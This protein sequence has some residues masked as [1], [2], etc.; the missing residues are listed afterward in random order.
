[1]L[2]LLS[3]SPIAIYQYIAL[4]NTFNC[5]WFNWLCVR[6]SLGRSVAQLKTGRA[7]FVLIASFRSHFTIDVSKKTQLANYWTL[8]GC[9]TSLMHLHQCIHSRN[10]CEEDASESVLDWKS[11]AIKSIPY[12]FHW[13]EKMK[14]SINRKLPALAALVVHYIVAK[15]IWSV[16]RL[17]KM[18]IPFGRQ[19][20]HSPWKRHPIATLARTV[21]LCIDMGIAVMC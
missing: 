20:C 3:S 4:C 17:V 2:L 12:F 10:L 15:M 11:T 19:R 1:M 8:G 6:C 14:H 7:T 13:T 21:P 18:A 5:R 9:Y 16:L